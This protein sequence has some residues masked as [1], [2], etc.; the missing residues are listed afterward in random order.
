MTEVTGTR[1][2]GDGAG[3]WLSGIAGLLIALLV[4]SLAEQAVPWTSGFYY[5]LG[6]PL[7]CAVVALVTWRYPLRAW[8]WA[9]AMAVGQVF[10]VILSG[11]GDMA[12]IALI[13]AVFLSVPQ[14]I[15]ASVLSSRRL[16]QLSSVPQDGN[17]QSDEDRP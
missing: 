14:F 16:A 7:M 13:Y 10:A 9:M 1:L 15:V 12:P 5:W 8:R 11:A 17:D 3:L 4:G 6:W 2:P